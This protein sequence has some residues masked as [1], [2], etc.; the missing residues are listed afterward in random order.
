ML[1]KGVS[2]GLLPGL[3]NWILGLVIVGLMV[4]AVKM[5]ELWGRVGVGLVVI[6]G[7]GNLIERIVYGAVIDNWNFFGLFYN[8]IWDYLIVAGVTV[9]LVRVLRR[10][11]ST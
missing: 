8:N 11:N 1:N 3:S 9:Y 10:G 7:V 5:R 6:G 4:Y 2:F